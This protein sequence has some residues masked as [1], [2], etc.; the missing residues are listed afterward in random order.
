MTNPPIPI[1]IFDVE[2]GPGGES[3]PLSRHERGDA[4]CAQQEREVE[5]EKD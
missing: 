3:I 5:D 1:E 2:D 4:I